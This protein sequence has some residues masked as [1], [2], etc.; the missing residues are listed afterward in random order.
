MSLFPVK[1]SL[2]SLTPTSSISLKSVVFIAFGRRVRPVE[3]L[4][5]FCA[6]RLPERWEPGGSET[7]T[8]Q[9]SPQEWELN[10]DAHVTGVIRFV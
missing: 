5:R 2:A 3:V 1:T 7:R 8:G 9:A 4:V 6:R 10:E